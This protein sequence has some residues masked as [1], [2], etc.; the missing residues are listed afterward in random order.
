MKEHEWIKPIADNL[1]PKAEYVQVEAA[2]ASSTAIMVFVKKELHTFVTNVSSCRVPTGFLGRMDIGAVSI[3]FDFHQTS[4]CFIN[5]H[6]AP[7]TAE[8]GR[9]NQEFDLIKIR[10]EFQ[11]SPNEFLYLKNHELIFWLGD[12]NYRL[13]DLS[14]D[15]VKTEIDRGNLQILLERDQLREQQ[16]LG[17]AFVDYREA[18]IDFVPSYKYDVGT[19]QFDTS[20]KN[21]APAWCDRILW[22]GNEP[23][24]CVQYRVHPTLLHSDHKP[25]SALFETT[26][27]V[28]D[29][30]KCEKNFEKDPNSNIDNASRR[31]EVLVDKLQI[32]F[33]Q[34]SFR[35][36]VRDA[37]TIR[38]T[39]NIDLC[40]EFAE[41][42]LWL[43]IRPPKG[44]L[45]VDEKKTLDIEICV[46]HRT[47][48]EMTRR[49]DQ[50]NSALVLK[51]TEHF[52]TDDRHKEIS[53]SLVGDYKLSSFGCSIET[54]VHLKK[55]FSDY[56]RKEI[57][58]LLEK[59]DNLNHSTRSIPPTETY[60]FEY[61]PNLTAKTENQANEL[62]NIPKELMFLVNEQMKFGLAVKEFFTRPSLRN[63]FSALRQATDKFVSDIVP[64]PLPGVQPFHLTSESILIFLDSMAQPVIPYSLYRR[65][66]ENSTSFEL[67][68]QL[69]DDVPQ[70]HRNVFHYIISFIQEIMKYSH[71]NR[72]SPDF[73][74]KIVFD[75]LTFFVSFHFCSPPP[76]LISSPVR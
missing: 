3:R 12:L 47:A 15:E 25:V 9:R 68:M 27:K 30:A 19:D 48:P 4:L 42:P 60:T 73:M 66:V 10:I 11:I 41:T 38:N 75:I 55:P 52:N 76:A 59:Y 8:V 46:D 31:L 57:V 49:R 71:I 64:T 35:D 23:T 21:R 65:A 29:L 1:H 34:I 74:G 54:L 24:N 37:L 44:I 53:I 20:A 62:L 13:N 51:L 14:P 45:A 18:A 43:T 61:D 26:I 16:K 17:T 28:I 56:D 50:I 63:E 67:S 5:S 7:H 39:G 33:G 36:I 22:K 32:N 72:R 2:S 6:L 69:I 70:S 58:D 40:F